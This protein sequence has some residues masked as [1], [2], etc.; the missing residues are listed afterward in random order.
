MSSAALPPP[1]ARWSVRMFVALGWSGAL[2]RLGV[3]ALL[4][5][6]I[7]R[8]D[9]ADMVSLWWHDS[10]YGHCLLL[11]PII[12]WLVAQRAPELAQLTPVGWWPGLLWCAAAAFGWLLGDAAGVAL[13]RQLGLVM[14]LQGAVL[15]ILGP[16][17]TR[18]LLFPWLFAFFLVPFG[19]ELVPP[20]QTLTAHMAMALL[21]LGGIPAYLDGIFITTPSGFFKVAE[22]CAGVNFIIAMAAYAALVA[23]LCFSSWRRR[24]AFVLFAIAVPVLANGVRAWGTILIAHHVGIDFAA[25]FDHVF[26]G[27]IFFAVVIALVMALAWG[28]FDRQPGDPAFD[29]A[30]LAGPVRWSAP[31]MPAMA[32]VLSLALAVAGW[33][34]FAGS[35]GPEAP[36]AIAA[37]RVAGWQAVPYRPQ[38]AWMPHFEGADVARL[39]RYRSND[40]AEVDVYVAL[41]AR[42]R[43]GAEVIGFGQGPVPPDS[44]WAWM[45]DS[46]SYG[47]MAGCRIRAP[48]PVIRD[49]AT[50]YRVAGTTSASP[51]AIKLA[52]LKGRLTG[53]DQRAAALIVSA[54]RR[55]GRDARADITAFLD[56]FGA[57]EGRVAVILAAAAPAP[58]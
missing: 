24:I 50:I 42:Q 36:A 15:T 51:L 19:D 13:L 31:A 32:A 22:A 18:G 26:Y 35:A 4:L 17:V 41:Y 45:A 3:T 44:D 29:P 5:L 34:G 39:I 37:P 43:E 47:A 56:D 10:T 6:V 25:S 28:Y 54:E 49:V 11:P 52:T 46:A 12:A 30:Q 2:V 57:P 53:G 21:G 55:E 27:W 20:M 48:G 7:F 33:S 40:G 16:Q 58:R 8:S 38:R 1:V 14:M 9:A 23:N